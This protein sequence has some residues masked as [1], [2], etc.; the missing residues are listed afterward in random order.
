METLLPDP[1][2]DRMVNTVVPPPQHAL[3]HN[4]LFPESKRIGKQEVPD[5]NVLKDHLLKEGRITKK[6]LIQIIGDVTEIMS[7][8]HCTYHFFPS[9]FQTHIHSLYRERTECIDGR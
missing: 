7:N 1:N 3:N 4:T 2:K 8:H 9:S 5:W 6:D